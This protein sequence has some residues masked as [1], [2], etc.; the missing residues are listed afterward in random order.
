MKSLFPHGIFVIDGFTCGERNDLHCS[1]L[2]LSIL[3]YPKPILTPCPD[4]DRIFPSS[5]NR[6]A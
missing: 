1:D 4:F 3:E 5:H 6:E 2:F